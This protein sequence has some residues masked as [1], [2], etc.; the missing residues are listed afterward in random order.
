M[1][2]DTYQARAKSTD[3]TSN[4]FVTSINRGA[5]VALLGLAGELG[6]LCATYKK[7]LRDGKNYK[8]KDSHI[9]EEL[10]DILWY[11]AIVADGFNLSLDE[12]A[13][14]NLKKTAGRWKDVVTKAKRFDDDMPPSQ[15][16]PRKFEIVLTQNRIDGRMKAVMFM[17][18][19]LLGDPLTDNADEADGYRFH[20]AFH[21][22]FLTTLGWSPVLRKLMGRKRRTNKTKDE[23]EDGGRAI[24][25]EEG[26]AAL[27]FEYGSSNGLSSGKHI[28]DDELLITIQQ[29]TRRLEVKDQSGYE[30]QK[31]ILTG[32]KTFSKL[33]KARGGR[34][35]CDLDKQSVRVLKL[36]ERDINKARRLLK[37]A[38]SMKTNLN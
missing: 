26:I 31:A 23:T 18:D 36:R 17:G 14:T 22:A 4:K 32:W 1:R 33:K 21:I 7:Y 25:I 24:V 20:D 37:D 30:W 38:K 13:E 15:R 28:L 5:V 8:L 34:I 2:L 35:I 29:M 16:L 19:Q 9:R 12:V 10:G 6:T 27:V 3:H 11:L